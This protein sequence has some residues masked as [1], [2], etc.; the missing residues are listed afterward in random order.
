LIAQLLQRRCPAADVGDLVEE[1]VAVLGLDP[2]RQVLGELDDAPQILGAQILTR[3][4]HDP[5]RIDA[6]VQQAGDRALH[7]DALA[8][9]T[10]AHEEIER[11][12]RDVAQ[13][14]R[15]VGAERVQTGLPQIGIP[16]LPT[17]GVLPPRVEIK[18][19]LPALKVPHLSHIVAQKH[20]KPHQ[21]QPI[22]R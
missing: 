11:A 7:R 16:L 4:E 5:P 18:Q 22:F 6:L 9:P 21:N 8:S 20:R 3:T 19:V 14:M 13:R 10:R 1:P 12:Q 2:G 17:P 15:V